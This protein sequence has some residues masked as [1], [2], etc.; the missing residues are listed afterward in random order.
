MNLLTIFVFVLIIVLIYTVYKLMTKTTST[1]SGFSDATKALSVPCDK[2][3]ANVNYGYSVWVYVDAWQN[4]VSAGNDQTVMKKNILTRC[5]G[6]TPA[7]NLYLDNAQN[8]LNLLING[9]TKACSIQNIKLQKWVNITMSIY[10]NTVDLYLDGK[11]VRTC[12][13]TTIPKAI[14]PS[15]TLYVGGAITKSASSCVA[16]DNGDLQGYISSV[17]YKPDYITP[18]EAWNIYSEG[19]SGAGMFDFVNRYKLNFS[20]TKDNQALGQISI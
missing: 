9:A 1:V 11:L 7:F 6:N 19:Y 12:I 10:G 13:L 5:I 2:F 17:V 18:E 20:I 4:T 16:T 8:N 3:G 15:D 14:K